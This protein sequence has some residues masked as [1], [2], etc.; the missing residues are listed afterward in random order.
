MKRP[1]KWI[2]GALLLALLAAGVLRAL[3]NRE[4]QKKALAQHVAEQKVQAVV[5][6]AAADVTSARPQE[7]AA[8]LAVSGPVRAVHSAF[9]KARVAGELMD[10]SVREGDFVKAGEVIARIDATETQARVRQALQQAEA[11]R[12]QVDIARRSFENNRSLVEQGFISR[13]ALETSNASLASAEASYR[14]AQAAADVLSKSLQDTVLKAPLSGQIAQRLAQ[15]GERVAVDT[16][17]VEVVDLS[18]LE[19]EVGLTAADSLQV[20]P[21]QVAE[22]RIDGAD[23]RFT[24]R[25]ARVSPS[26]SA[27]NRAVLA[28]LAVDKGTPLRQGLFAQGNLA[29]GKKQGIALPLDTVRTDKPQPYVQVVKQGAVAHLT[30]TPSMPGEVQGAAYVLLDNVPEGAVVLRGSVGPLREGT[31]VKLQAVAP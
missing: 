29:V 8:V 18:A 13:T 11:A 5:D 4:A 15:P 21:G 10:L 6:V 27:S 12:A 20:R 1:V 30:V 17:I 2:L 19:I 26:A 3:S 23:Q 24:A 28:Y 16:R 14:A 7:L 25:V 31:P 22:M 9:V